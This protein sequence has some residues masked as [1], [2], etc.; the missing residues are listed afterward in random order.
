MYPYKVGPWQYVYIQLR[1]PKLQ[2]FYGHHP[3]TTAV[4]QFYK[5]QQA[6]QRRF[7]D[8]MRSNKSMRASAV[9]PDR[10]RRFPGSPVVIPPAALLSEKPW[11]K[12]AGYLSECPVI[13]C[14]IR[15]STVLLN[16]TRVLQPLQ[17]NGLA[18]TWST[19]LYQRA[20][21]RFRYSDEVWNYAC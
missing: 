7:W 3:T 12:T 10:S 6:A 2:H 9:E 15:S 14:L 4:H 17:F 18:N 8:P 5:S 1:L 21:K 13:S 19:A 16:M 20:P 11:W